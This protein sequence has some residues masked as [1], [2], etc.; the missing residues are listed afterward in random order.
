VIC[1][2]F[3]SVD[4]DNL[5]DLERWENEGGSAM[6]ATTK[7]SAEMKLSGEG[8]EARDAGGGGAREFEKLGAPFRW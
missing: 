2:T 6:Q 7:P 3:I 4:S 8:M 1:F 5:T